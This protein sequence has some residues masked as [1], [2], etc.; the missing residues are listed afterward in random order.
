MR[1]QEL[2]YRIAEATHLE[3]LEDAFFGWTQIETSTEDEPFL[4]GHYANQQSV[5]LRKFE[6]LTSRAV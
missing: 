6:R 5:Q 1:A 4:T 3:T 2:K